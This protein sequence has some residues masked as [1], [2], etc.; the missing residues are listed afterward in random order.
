ME[1][2]MIDEKQ[3]PTIDM[4]EGSGTIDDNVCCFGMVGLAIP[5]CMSQKFREY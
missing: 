1:S 3:D 5:S 4:L 2:T